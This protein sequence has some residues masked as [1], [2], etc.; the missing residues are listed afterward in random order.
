[1]AFAQENNIPIVDYETLLLQPEI[2]ELI[3]NDVA[4]LVGPHTG[5]KPFE[6]VFKFK[7]LAKPFE[8]GRELS[9]KQEIMRHRVV[10]LYKKEIAELFE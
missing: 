9:H 8:V 3:A 4:D 1:M 10:E 5:F 7:L 6:R 2:N